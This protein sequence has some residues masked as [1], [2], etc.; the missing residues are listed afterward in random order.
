[1]TRREPPWIVRYAPWLLAA[2]ITI[3]PPGLAIAT[4]YTDLGSDISQIL[5]SIVF[6][7]VTPVFGAS[8][9]LIISRQPGNSIGWMLMLVG[10]GVSISIVT[11][12]FTPIVAPSQISAWMAVLV[13]LGSA[14]WLAFLF[15]IF[16]IL[17]TFPTGGVMSPRWRGIVVFE[18]ALASFL[19]LTA[20][21]G[22]TIT[23]NTEAWSVV[24]PISPGTSELLDAVAQF[25]SILG[26]LTLTVV[27][28]SAIAIRFRRSRAV[29]RQQIKA[30]FYAVTMWAVVYAAAI[31]GLANS[32]WPDLLIPIGMIGIGLAIALALFRYRLYD[33]DRIV[34]RT[35]SYALVVGLLGSMFLGLAT[36]VGSRFSEQPIFVASTTLAVAG[37]FNPVRKRIQV[38]VERRFN[39][40][41]FD[42]QRVMT[43]FAETLRHRVDPDGLIEGWVGVVSE[44]MQPRSKSIWVRSGTNG[45]T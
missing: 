13:A 35:V 26:L 32:T 6:L 36:L 29:E 9:A 30:L 40:S 33:I 3:V 42:A 22:E 5:G 43:E 20:V 31:L 12:L 39:R 21:F 7:L 34:S 17:L 45:T 8:A 15:P 23:P 27:C 38:R 19:I 28:T 14:S 16:H 44:T 25:A 24:N 18:I 10:I 1:M 11:D 2:T 37:A 41:R 4:G